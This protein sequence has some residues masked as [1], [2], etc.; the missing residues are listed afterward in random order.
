MRLS[1]FDCFLQ[2]RKNLIDL[3]NK[4]DLTKDEFIEENFYSV[5]SLRI[6]PFSKI[7]NLKKAIFNYQY[8]NVMAKY[9]QKKAHILNKKSYEAREDFLNISKDYYDKKDRVT[10]RLLNLIDYNNTT[11]Y[12]VRVKSSKLKKKLFEIVIED[13]DLIVLHSKNKKVLNTLK[14]EK[15]FVD[16]VR[17]SLTDNY[18]NQKY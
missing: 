18:I 4:G 3:Y 9:Y 12:F 17:T 5:K 11:A 10:L 13:D 7:D 6:K 8:F 1:K 15:I 14:E 2:N 16:E